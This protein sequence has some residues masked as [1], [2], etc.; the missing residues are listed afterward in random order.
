MAARITDLEQQIARMQREQER[1]AEF[2]RD[3]AN[4]IARLQGREPPYR[5]IEPTKRHQGECK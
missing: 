3:R 2:G 1:W 5:T 4:Q